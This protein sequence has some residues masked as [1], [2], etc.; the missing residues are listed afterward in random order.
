MFQWYALTLAIRRYGL[1][2]K[3]AAEDYCQSRLSQLL[4]LFMLPA[5]SASATSATCFGFLLLVAMRK[6]ASALQNAIPESFLIGVARSILVVASP[7]LI[8]ESLGQPLH[9]D[10]C[11]IS[12]LVIGSA[13]GGLGNLSACIV[14]LLMLTGGEAL[15]ARAFRRVSGQLAALSKKLSPPALATRVYRG[16]PPADASKGGTVD[17]SETSDSLETECS[18]VVPAVSIQPH[19]VVAVE[20]GG[21]VAFDGI[22][23]G[24]RTHIGNTAA[25]NHVVVDEHLL[26]GETS[27]VVRNL[28]DRVLAGAVVHHHQ[29]LN[30]S[31]RGHVL[32]A[33]V[34]YCFGYSTW[35]GTY[36]SLGAVGRP[37]LSTF[38]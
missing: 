32:V 10:V 19:D 18:T 38:L 29:V 23:C 9:A 13:L 2:P 12:S 4:H 34:C 37:R 11:A 15:E 16:T 27:L 7:T 25:C 8:L 20:P 35:V 33:S 24:V 5:P 31:H 21:I 30:R 1:P 3:K 26:T 17:I 22:L 28:G 14:I 6:S 36:F